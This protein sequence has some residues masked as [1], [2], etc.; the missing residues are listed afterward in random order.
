[1]AHAAVHPDLAW[2][3][4]FL[5][6]LGRIL[7]NPR[8]LAVA[9][10]VGLLGRGSPVDGVRVSSR[11][12]GGVPVRIYR[13]ASAVTTSAP[14]LLWLHGGGL[15]MGSAALD[16]THASEVARDLGVL[17]V[18]V[19]Y[20]LAP[21][22][23]FPAA[24]DDAHAAWRHLAAAPHELG[25]DVERLAVGGQSAGGGLAAA[26]VQRIRDEGGPQPVAQWLLCPM[27]DDRT[28]ARRELDDAGHLVWDNRLNRFGWRS[29]L[30]EEPGAEYLPVYAAPARCQDLRR[31]PPAWIG[32][33]SVDLFLDEA[34]T[35]ADRLRA[36]DVDVDIEVVDGAPHGFEA[37]ARS[38]P[39]AREFL[40]TA[41]RWL[42]RYL[43]G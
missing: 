8:G 19:D 11:E 27:L 38:T 39:V 13:P 41:T 1:M 22:A 14:G 16:D 6:P 20:R 9:R 32:I 31:L 42:G 7:A 40:D 21:E 25:V 36:A 5:P 23:P 33:G 37:W 26:L 2:R 24:L 4:R 35:Y 15:V 29:Y 30:G 17:V 28:A 3:V 34:S 18:S 10:R 12:L 43:T